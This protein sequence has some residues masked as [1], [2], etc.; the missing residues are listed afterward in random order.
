[1]DKLDEIM[2]HKRR[3]VATRERPVRDHDLA[4]FAQEP[5]RGFAQVLAAA[6]GLGIIA[7]VKRR[8]PS[9]GAI[10]PGIDAA[11][12][13]RLYYNA[14]A[15]CL[16]VLTDEAYFGGSIRDLW[17]VNDLLGRREDAPPTLRKDFFVHPLQVLEAAEAGA[18]CIL[19]I[20]RALSDEEIRTLYGAAQ[21]AG[22]DALFEIHN[23][24]ELERALSFEPKLLGVNNRDLQR[25][26]TDLAISEK[27]LPQVP[28]GII[29]VGESGIQRAEDAARMREAG[30]D[31]LLVG[32]ALMRAEDKDKLLRELKY[33]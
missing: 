7:E 13:A 4:A 23:E 15:D 24:P 26:C 31:A 9:A 1:M 25:F 16:S 33:A 17:E 14:R 29:T 18:S 19:I 5:R 8:S 6:E 30:A 20:V 3:E 32:E 12:Q 27:L 22:L 21:L 28:E 2:A 10:A 11:E